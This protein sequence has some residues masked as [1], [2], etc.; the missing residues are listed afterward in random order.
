ML[1][2]DHKMLPPTIRPAQSQDQSTA[3]G[4]ASHTNPIGTARSQSKRELSYELIMSAKTVG[5][6][7]VFGNYIMRRSIVPQ[8][9]EASGLQEKSQTSNKKLP[10]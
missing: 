6:S 7:S 8:E 9:V 5:S 10:I 1:S 4:E 2:G 3:G